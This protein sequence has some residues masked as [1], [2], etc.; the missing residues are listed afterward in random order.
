MLGKM[1][2]Q[3]SNKPDE[4]QKLVSDDGAGGE[5]GLRGTI[6]MCIVGCR[7]THKHKPTRTHP[8]TLGSKRQYIVCY[9]L[10]SWRLQARMMLLS[11]A[12]HMLWT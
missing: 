11:A 5:G 3:R 6:G 1:W 2:A 7:L 4:S 9:R 8:C 10:S 12:T